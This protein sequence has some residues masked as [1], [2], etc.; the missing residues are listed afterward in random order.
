MNRLGLVIALTVATTPA[1]AQHAGHGAP[2]APAAQAPTAQ[3]YAGQQ[4]R[5]ISSLSPEDVQGFLDGRGMGLAKPAELNGF[6]GPMH[7]LEHD[8]DLALTDAQRAKVKASM[9]AMKAKARALGKRYVEAEKA[10]DDAFR[11]NAGAQRIAARVVVANK[12]LGDIRMA[13]LAAHLEITPL[14]SAQQRSKY[15]ELRGYTGGAH[16]P[17]KHKH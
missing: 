13:H 12:L 15:A 16:D 9:D 4:A 1:L 2:P 6:P 7:V 3:P 17:S 5:N 11:A 14:L 8:K 10:V